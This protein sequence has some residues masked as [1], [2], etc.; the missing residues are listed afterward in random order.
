ML[1]LI[2]LL[3]AMIKRGSLSWVPSFSIGLDNP[4][5]L[6]TLVRDGSDNNLILGHST[7]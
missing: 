5:C 6:A 3:L 2:P 4:I 7:S 1:L